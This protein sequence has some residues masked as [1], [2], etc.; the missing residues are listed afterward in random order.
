MFNGGTDGADALAF[1]EEF[2]GGEDFA[3]VYFKQARCVE[4][5]WRLGELLCACE[6]RAEE[7]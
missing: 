3:G 1:Y 4:D 6:R 2:A 7:E 5:D